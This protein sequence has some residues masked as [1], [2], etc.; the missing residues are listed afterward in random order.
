M[1]GTKEFAL[2]SVSNKV[3]LVPFARR[4]SELG[5][6]LAASGGTANKIREDGV[7]VID[8][9]ELTG[10]PEML[11]GRVKTLHPAIHAGILARKTPSDEED[12]KKQGF[13]YIKLVV[14]NLYPFEE[15]IA[16]QDITIADAVENIDIGGVALLR[17]AAKNHDRVT[18]VCDPRDYDAV[19]DEMAS[20][21]DR[22]TTTKTRQSLAV[23]AFVH[24]ASYDEMISDYFR[25]QYS[26]GNSH[27]PLRYGMNP[28]QSP[29]QLFTIDSSLPLRVWNGSPGFIN[30]LDALNAWQLVKELKQAL[31][32]PAAAS[33]KHVS[34]AGAAVAVP[35]TDEQAKLCMVSDMQQTLSPLAT[36]YARARGADRMSSFGDFIALSDVCDL[37]TAQIISKEVSDGVI[38]PGYEEAALEVFRKKKGGK[39]CVLEIDPT[40]TPH[41]METRTLFGLQLQQRRNNAV[42]DKSFFSNIVTKHKDLPDDAVRDLIVATIAVKY[43]QSN[44]VCYARDGQVIGLGAGQQSRIHCT[45]LAGEKAQN[46]WM[47]QHPRVLGMQFAKGKK[48]AEMSNAIDS[49]VTGVVGQDVPADDWKATFVTPPEPFTDEERREWLSQLKGV[50][51]S[52]DAFFPF[53]DNIDRAY[54]NGVQY[55]AAP[56]GS[57]QDAAVI[58]AANDH[59]MTLIHTNTRLFHH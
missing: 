58:S 28:H 38:A 11:G 50:S 7:P 40:F 17:A 49:F 10:Q 31:S 55:V 43:S 35:L 16:K 41:E 52:S 26:Q 14:C 39:Y 45:R 51:L 42:V 5:V 21:A 1:A 13:S 48:R 19:I 30:L 57:A 12:M 29:A 33:F 32:L 22:D 27:L 4:L 3:G 37:S 24:T 25:K 59:N 34:P 9:A 36:A 6:R 8:V 56:G 23:K 46:W 44:S 2:L 18:V 15:T 47:R 20:N 54:Q 53:R